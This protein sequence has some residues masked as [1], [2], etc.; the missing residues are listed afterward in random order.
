M[1]KWSFFLAVVFV[2]SLI[3]CGGSGNGNG[4]NGGNGGTGTTGTT[5]TT[6][7]TGR[8]SQ[9]VNIPNIPGLVDTYI[10]PTQGRQSQSLFTDIGDIVYID[11]NGNSTVLENT[12]TILPVT[13]NLS[14]PSLNPQNYPLDV[15]VPFIG[16]NL[17]ATDRNFNEMELFFNDFYSDQ[18]QLFGPLQVPTPVQATAYQGRITAIQLYLNDGMFNFGNTTGQY[19]PLEYDQFLAQNADPQTGQLGGFLADYLSIDLSGV[20]VA[21]RPIMSNN[22]RAGRLF[23]SGDDFAVAAGTP[24]GAGSYFEVLTAFGVFP[25]MA[26]ISGSNTQGLPTK[27]YQLTQPNILSLTNPGNVTALEGLW[28]DFA[29]RISATDSTLMITF[30]PTG[31]GSIQEFAIVQ[32][33][34]KVVKGVTTNVFPNVYYGTVNYTA[35]GGPAF[36]AYPIGDLE[37]G[38]VIGGISGTFSGMVDGNGVAVNTK[39]ASWWRFVHAGKFAVTKGAAVGIA[40]S[41]RFVVYRV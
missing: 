11:V 3:G 5:A 17:P 23:I 31:D 27:T 7:T 16:S 13:V 6:G 41:G 32:H 19:G 34:T 21:S 40:P 9:G 24:G 37:P 4:G 18:G 1:R 20:P 30:P 10:E 2:I 22:V 26:Y 25:G 14:S 36:T 12:Q 8:V 15:T 38:N 33:T 28:Y 35:P 39:A 29:D